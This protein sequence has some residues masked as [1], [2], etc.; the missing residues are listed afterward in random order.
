MAAT[1]RV[2][3]DGEKPGRRRR[4]PSTVSQAVKEGTSRDVLT[5]LRA[6]IAQTIDDPGTPPRDLAALSRRLVDIDKELRAMDAVEREEAI[7]GG[8]ATGDGDWEAI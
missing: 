6:R 4:T 2:V 5:T 8:E 7:Q 1:L 3:S